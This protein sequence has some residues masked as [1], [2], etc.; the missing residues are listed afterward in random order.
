MD[1]LATGAVTQAPLPAVAPEPDVGQRAAQAPSN[2]RGT[3][4]SVAQVREQLGAIIDDRDVAGIR[5]RSEFESGGLTVAPPAGQLDKADPDGSEGLFQT[6]DGKHAVVIDTVASQ[7]NR[8]EE[9][10]KGAASE[11]DYPL[12]VVTGVE[13]V[14]R[15][16][17]S[18]DWPHRQADAHWRLLQDQAIREGHLSDEDVQAIRDA[19]VWDAEAL[20]RWFPASVLFGWWHSVPK[21]TKTKTTAENQTIRNDLRD[22]R[23]NVAA[24][25]SAARSARVVTSE[26]IAHGVSVAPRL[27][28]RIDPFGPLPGGTKAAPSAYSQGGLV[29]LPPSKSN[30]AVTYE[31]IEGA[32]F[33]GFSHL[34]H[35]CFGECTGEGRVLALAL[36]LLAVT[37]AR[38]DLHLRSGADLILKGKPVCTLEGGSGPVGFELPSRADLVGLVR[39]IG[40]GTFGWNG[41]LTIQAPATYLRIASVAAEHQAAAGGDEG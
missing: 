15:R 20:L 33:I 18:L 37:E 9:A 8:M 36:S 25:T 26:V 38:Y 39:S 5:I 22:A 27:C 41:P 10:L 32:T 13:R 40:T 28:A 23:S 4:V 35:F 34:R 11:V 14:G 6:S 3:P 17:T 30:P 19:T 24:N 1:A 7:A 29:T 31:R 21:E 12:F 16:N 2:E